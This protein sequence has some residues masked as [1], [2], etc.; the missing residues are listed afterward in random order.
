MD[1]LMVCRYI[2][3]PLLVHRPAPNQSQVPMF[4]STTASPLSDM[5]D[6]ALAKLPLPTQTR[7][8]L[9]IIYVSLWALREGT[10]KTPPILLARTSTI[11]IYCR[12]ALSWPF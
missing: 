7:E 8:K 11:Y 1:L 5:A 2:G 4:P 3:L 12:Q 9:T 10:D 6:V